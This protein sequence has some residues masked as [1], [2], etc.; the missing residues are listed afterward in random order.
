MHEGGN[1]AVFCIKALDGV[2]D[3]GVIRDRGADVSERTGGGLLLEA[4]GGDALVSLDD[5]ADFF[6]EVAS[7]GLLVVTE[8][9]SDAH[10]VGE[11]R[12]SIPHDHVG[13]VG[14]DGAVEL[15]HDGGVQP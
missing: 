4:V 11:G 1:A 7:P 15:A 14:G 6:A 3:E 10:E 5:V 8:D 2:P 13:D 9:G 12:V